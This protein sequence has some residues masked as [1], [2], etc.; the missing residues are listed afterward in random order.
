MGEEIIQRFGLDC[1][2]LEILPELWQYIETLSFSLHIFLKSFVSI[3]SLA[4]RTKVAEAKATPP[5]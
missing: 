4:I 3:L 1:T 2:Y 5:A